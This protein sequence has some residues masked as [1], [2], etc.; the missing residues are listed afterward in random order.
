MISA[1]KGMVLDNSTMPRDL[2]VIG[3]LSYFF[4]PV[5]SPDP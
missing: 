5:K 4:S 2:V 3:V 1:K